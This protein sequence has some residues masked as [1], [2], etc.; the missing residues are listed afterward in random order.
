MWLGS[1]F[2]LSRLSDASVETNS[3]SSPVLLWRILTQG[4]ILALAIRGHVRDLIGQVHV[5]VDATGRRAVGAATPIFMSKA[6]VQRGL[7]SS[8][9]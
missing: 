3:V 5:P 8:L 6:I 7:S 1:C 9:K 4:N 2:R